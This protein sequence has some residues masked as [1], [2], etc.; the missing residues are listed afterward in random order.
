M[1]TVLWWVGNGVVAA[2]VLPAVA[3]LAVRIMRALG[4]VHRA[5][6]DIRASLRAVAGG[7]PPAVDGLAGVAARCERLGERVG[8]RV[9]A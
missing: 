9:G 2:L 7:I 3:L 6:T 1:G 4:V 8:E 5:A